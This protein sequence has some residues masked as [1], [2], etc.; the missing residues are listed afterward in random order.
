M[1][2]NGAFSGGSNFQTDSKVSAKEKQAKLEKQKALI[3]NME[4]G[5]VANQ[6]SPTQVWGSNG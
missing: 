2:F 6:Q 1:G 5:H 4:K 3:K